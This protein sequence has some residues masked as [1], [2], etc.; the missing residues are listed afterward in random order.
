MRAHNGDRVLTY[1]RAND[2]RGGLWAPGPR[3]VLAAGTGVYLDN[4]RREYYGSHVIAS[5]ERLIVIETDDHT[6]AYLSA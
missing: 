4:G 1:Q 5:D 2:G 6:V 3:T